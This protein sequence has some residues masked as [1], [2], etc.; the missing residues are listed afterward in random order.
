MGSKAW[1]LMTGKMV[2]FTWQRPRSAITECFTVQNKLRH[3]KLSYR[4]ALKTQ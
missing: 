3:A 2:T 1:Q 4:K